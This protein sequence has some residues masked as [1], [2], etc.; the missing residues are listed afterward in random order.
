MCYEKVETTRAVM[1]DGPHITDKISPRFEITITRLQVFVLK[2]YFAVL[3]GASIFLMTMFNN[4][5]NEKQKDKNKT[6]SLTDPEDMSCDFIYF[7]LC[8]SCVAI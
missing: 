8:E 2:F 7:I 6:K 3:S 4:H 5:D 1:I